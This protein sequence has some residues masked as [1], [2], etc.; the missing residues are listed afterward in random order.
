MATTVQL[1]RGKKA[2]VSDSKK[3]AA[4]LLRELSEEKIKVAL[5]FLEFL[6]FLDQDGNGKEF[7]VTDSI[8]QGIKELAQMRAKKLKPKSF[9][10]FWDE[11]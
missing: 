11:L 1:Q 5:P 7:K 6:R 8:K 10:A 3:K 4:Y 9:E 2:S